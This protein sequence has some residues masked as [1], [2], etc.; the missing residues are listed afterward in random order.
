MLRSI[1][2]GWLLAACHT[3]P[4]APN[5]IEAGALRASVARAREDA[6]VV[7]GRRYAV[8]APVRLW[9]EDPFYDAYSTVP[10]FSSEGPDGLRYHPGRKARSPELAGR[11]AREG[12][13][14]RN[15]RE[16]VDLFVLHYDVAGTSESC[17]KIL[18]DR[19]ELS[20]HFLLDVDGTIYQTLDLREQAWHA[21]QANPRSVGIEIANIGA[22]E[23]GKK[24]A[25]D[26]WYVRDRGG[27]S[28]RLPETLG[29][30]GVR[31]KGFIARPA[32]H[33]RVRGT[34]HGVTY[35]QYDFTPQQYRSLVAL[36]AALNEAFPNIELQIPRDG[37]GAIRSDALSASEFERYRGIIG[38][39]H[40]TEAKRD[41]GPAFDW[42]RFLSDAQRASARY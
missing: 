12:W 20:V 6:I 30:G 13:T 31:S 38:H 11:V 28:L 19:R 40:L 5:P 23:P 37:R 39:Q 14:L 26:K 32:R 7:C 29:D 9:T 35:E 33:R 8:D 2:L 42:E 36:T 25:L 34:V 15:L 24:S 17:F 41:P 21:R 27:V 22:Y 4:A 10:R 3:P 18:Q 16:Q 1:L